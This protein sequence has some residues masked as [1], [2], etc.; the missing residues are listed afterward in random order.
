MRLN[1]PEYRWP[2]L[3]TQVEPFLAKLVGMPTA[4]AGD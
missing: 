2:P 4:A 3:Q 1:E